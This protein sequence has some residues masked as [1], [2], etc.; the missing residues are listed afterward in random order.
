MRDCPPPASRPRPRPRVKV[1]CGWQLRAGPKGRAYDGAEDDAGEAA[2]DGERDGALVR[3]G[4]A[5]ARRA[6]AEDD[7]QVQA[8]A[9]L[10]AALALAVDALRVVEEAAGL[11]RNTGAARRSL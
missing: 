7:G 3:V 8:L 2:E 6:H 4:G 5:E 10:C 11:Q 9:A 1:G